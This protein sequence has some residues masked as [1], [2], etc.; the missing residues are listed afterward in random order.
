M[1][2]SK[3]K[4]QLAMARACMDPK[5]L[6]AAAEMPQQTVNGVIK[7]RSVRPATFGRICKALGCDPEDILRQEKEE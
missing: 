5:D 1:K 7:G 4:L 2:A 3:N 6:A